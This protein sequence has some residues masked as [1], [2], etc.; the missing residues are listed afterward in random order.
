MTQTQ[1]PFEV[2]ADRY[3]GE[4]FGYCY[5]MLGSPH[6]AEDAV[7]ETYLRAW[8]GYDGFEGRAS[9]RTWLYRIATRVCL[10]ALQHRTRRALP[11]GLGGPATD[12]LGP[13]EPHLSETAWVEPVSDA[14]LDP[15]AVTEARHTTRLA[16]VAALQHLPGRQRAVLV[17]RDVLVF[18]ADEVADLLDTTTAAVNSALQ[19]ARSQLAKSAPLGYDLAEP[20]D[21]LRHTLL[22]RYTEAFENADIDGLL[23]ILAED[24]VL[25]MPPIP[26]WFCGRDNIAQFLRTRL[27]GPGALRLVPTSANGQAAYGLYQRGHDGVHQAHALQLLTIAPAGVARIDMI[28][29]AT[30]FPRFGL[31]SSAPGKDSVD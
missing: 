10:Q 29:D 28:H 20:A 26:A 3:R 30:L 8:R 2:A 24:A 19:R 9:V 21:P 31:P 1:Q 25:E 23:R 14:E 22:E 18:R 15:A 7:Q 27:T 13:L 5:R 4:L 6:D 16:F 17:L 11:S 12:P